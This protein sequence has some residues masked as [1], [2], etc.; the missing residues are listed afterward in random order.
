M[1]ALEAHPEMAAWTGPGGAGSAALMVCP[2]IPS[3]WLRL[4]PDGVGCGCT[5]IFAVL[6]V[7]LSLWTDMSVAPVLD[8]SVSAEWVSN[9]DM[10]P[11][12]TELALPGSSGG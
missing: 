12:F 6:P 3:I 10:V 4:P 1:L 2:R 9:R 5:R 11:A 7:K 8:G